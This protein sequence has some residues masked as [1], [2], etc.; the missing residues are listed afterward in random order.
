MTNRLT[1]S[2]PAYIEFRSVSKLTIVIIVCQ[3]EP[4]KVQYAFR[5]KLLI[6]GFCRWFSISTSAISYH[7]H[8]NIFF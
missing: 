5:L 2:S 1:I 7:A 4:I 8:I 6:N 3:N